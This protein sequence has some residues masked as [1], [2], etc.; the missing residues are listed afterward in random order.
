MD[1]NAVVFGLHRVVAITLKLYVS[2]YGIVSRYLVLS[3]K[4]PMGTSGVT[5]TE[6][7]MPGSN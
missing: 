7:T 3:V 1:L 5:S 6:Y 2:L 4:F